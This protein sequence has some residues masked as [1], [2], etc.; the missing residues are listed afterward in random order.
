MVEKRTDRIQI[1]NFA[2]LGIDIFT[3]VQVNLQTLVEQVGTVNYRGPNAHS[4]KRSCVTLAVHF[5]EQ[6]TTTMTSMSTVIEA[7]TSFIATALGG[8]PIQIMPPT[9]AITPPEI[10][11]DESVEAAEDTALRN[12][13]E[14]VEKVFNIIVALFEENLAN[15]KN[16]GIDGWWGPEYDDTL[17]S[18]TQLTGSAV[19][20]CTT[21]R[22]DINSAIQTQ[23]DR[24]F[25]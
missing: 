12:L 5:A 7:N 3:K 4:F 21:S 9:V 13:S 18:M 6:T 15:L 10:S 16:L 19:E 14:E 22:T 2:N 17:Q 1:Q 20:H 8:Q 24:L 23:I 11:G 25:G